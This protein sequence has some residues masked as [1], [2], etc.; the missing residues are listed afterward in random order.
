[1]RG[2]ALAKDCRSWNCRAVCH[3]FL[4]V[5]TCAACFA[6]Q[7]PELVAG[8]SNIFRTEGVDAQTGIHYVRL[9]LVNGAAAENGRAPARFTV[10]CTDEGGKK[11]MS[12][13]VTFGGVRWTGFVPPFRPTPQSPVRPNYPSAKLKM[14]FEG[15]M[16][17]KPVTRSWEML[18]SGEWR[19]R[20]PGMH[21]PNMESLR[22][23]LTWLNSL[24]T[25]RIAIVQP[26]PGGAQEE[27]FDARP[28]LNEMA[29]VP[30]CQP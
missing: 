14:G 5:T 15:Y 11:D 20:N 3:I 2:W 25:L 10:E 27:V 29:K 28:L 12:W 18:P 17:W 4:F 26:Q 8:A 19:Y 22:Y 23:Y 7:A 16:K 24:P 21:S 6:Q 13:L 1:M 9:M 30:V